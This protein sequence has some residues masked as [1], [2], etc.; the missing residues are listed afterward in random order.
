MKSNEFAIN[1]LTLTVSR[2]NIY[3][4]RIPMPQTAAKDEDGIPVYP[5]EMFKEPERMK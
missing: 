2:G 4:V 3:S 1:V 5:A